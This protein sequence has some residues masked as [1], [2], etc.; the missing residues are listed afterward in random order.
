LALWLL[1]PVGA[2]ARSRKAPP[3]YFGAM[4]DFPPN[5]LSGGAL[6][7]QFG[8]MA[9]SGVESTRVVFDWDLIQPEPGTP[10]WQTTDGLVRLAASHGLRLLPIVIYTPRWASSYK[11]PPTSYRF[12]P[13]SDLNTY[14]AFLTALIQRYG[15]RG[16]FWAANPGL[17]KVALREWQIWNE[18]SSRTR[19]APADYPKSFT[20][21]LKVAYRAVHRA[22]RGAKVVFPGLASFLQ[23]SGRRTTSWDDQRAFY[24]HGAR[25]YFDVAAINGFAPTL[26]RV[27]RIVK[28]HRKV[29]RRYHDARKPI[30]LTEMTWPASKGRIPR[31]LLLSLEVTPR[32]QPKLLARG[33]RYFL[34]KR[35]LRVRRIYWY[36]WASTYQ[37]F[38]CSALAVTFQY[39]G[40]VQIPCRSAT[41]RPMRLLST[42]ARTARRY[43]GCRKT[44]D[45]RRCKR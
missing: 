11:N 44:N 45:A 33:F 37:P 31:D 21:L 40:L 6:D 24:R 3:G 38:A 14:G 17:P 9:R 34:V 23:S 2:D 27:I 43:E 30:Y 8:L 5:Q 25:R 12:Y 32:A 29:M 16:T 39:T 7:A 4:I 15:P 13:P 19:W 18:P 10:H 35:S 28:E 36:N 26:G 41:A 42:F 1:L 22:D 20:R